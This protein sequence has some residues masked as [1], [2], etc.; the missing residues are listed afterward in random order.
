MRGAGRV[1]GVLAAAVL[2]CLMLILP[3]VPLGRVPDRA[4]T[5]ESAPT[6]AP[7]P[8]TTSTMGRPNFLAN[9]QSRVSWAGTAMMAPVP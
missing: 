8:L 4:A 6:A 1:C 5:P 9:S 7:S 2:L 3:A